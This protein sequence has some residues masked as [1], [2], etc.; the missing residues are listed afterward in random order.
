M[1][2]TRPLSL[3]KMAKVFHCDRER[4]SVKIALVGNVGGR[5]VENIRTEALDALEGVFDRHLDSAFCP[6]LVAFPEP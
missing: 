3:S 1:P 6:D 5:N 4:D 2:S